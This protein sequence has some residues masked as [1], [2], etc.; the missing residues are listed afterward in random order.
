MRFRILWNKSFTNAL[1]L[2]PLLQDS[3]G[4]GEP[5]G[6]E[7]PDWVAVRSARRAGCGYRLARGE[8]AVTCRLSVESKIT[9]IYLKLVN[10]GKRSRGKTCLG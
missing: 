7:Y 1:F 10:P 8:G 4:R 6:I 2:L 3:S 5:G 9:L